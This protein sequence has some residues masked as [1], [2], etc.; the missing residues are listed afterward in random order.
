[1]VGIYLTFIVGNTWKYDSKTEAYKIYLNE[2]SNDDGTT[3]API[4]YFRVN[5][6][7]YECRTATNN[8]SVPDESKNIVY[9]DSTNPEN[10][11]TQYEKSTGRF[12]GVI[13]IIVSI[14]TVYLSIKQPSKDKDYYELEEIDLE[15]QYQI[16]EKIEK[17]YPIL[18]KVH[19]I[20]KRIIL[21]IIILALL[22]II[23]VDT[24]ILRQTIISKDY[25]ETIAT[26]VD[27]SNDEEDSIFYRCIYTFQDK[28]GNKQEIIVNVDKEL[29]IKEK[30]K[31]RYDEN[32]PQKYYR[33]ESTLDRTEFIWYIVIIIVTILLIIVFFNK[34]LLN[35]ISISTS[36][37]NTN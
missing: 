11:K 6:E 14:L 23:V 12:V 29:T 34:K 10:C 28:Q 17:L 20:Y 7:N 1:M 27:K 19:L 26:Y 5:G 30:I 15:K 8:S 4:Y 9:Y 22:V 24:F 35:K 21:G 36:V 16:E 32:N 37:S 18:E 33:E 25:I 13:F 31:I 3:Y 2:F